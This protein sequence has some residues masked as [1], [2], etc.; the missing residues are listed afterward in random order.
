MVRTTLPVEVVRSP[1]R[2]K[3]V[4]AREVDGKLRVAIPAWMSRAE[5]AHWVD[6]MQRRFARARDR[7]VDLDRRA[8]VLAGRYG[9]PVPSSVRWSDV[10]RARW[11]S[12][13]PSSGE[14]RISSRLERFPAWVLDYVL[15]HEMAHLRHPDH[16][17]HFWSLVERYPLTERARGFLI[18]MDLDG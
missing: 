1:R 5:E 16:G 13:T 6:E 14:I 7:S 8:G 11:G 4:E 2:R 17:S 15:V 12:C 10:Q 18:A 9:L 3:T